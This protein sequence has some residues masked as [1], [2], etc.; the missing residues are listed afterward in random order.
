MQPSGH[1]TA[2]E[3][4]PVHFSQLCCWMKGYPLWF[5]F[6]STRL[7]RFSGQASMHSLQ[8]L[9]RSVST[10]IAPLIIVMDFLLAVDILVVKV[11]DFVGHF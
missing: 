7:R 10:T 2:H 11:E 4:Q 8:P 3:V 5:T 1:T 6:L 9:H